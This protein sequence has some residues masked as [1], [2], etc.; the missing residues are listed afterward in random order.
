VPKAPKNTPSNTPTVEQ[1]R[2]FDIPIFVGIDHP[3]FPNVPGTPN[4]TN[5]RK[6]DGLPKDRLPPISNLNSMLL[7]I[8][9]NKPTGARSE[10]SRNSSFSSGSFDSGLQEGQPDDGSSYKVRK[11]SFSSADSKTHAQMEASAFVSKKLDAEIKGAKMGLLYPSPPSKYNHQLRGAPAHPG[12]SRL[13]GQA[14]GPLGPLTPPRTPHNGP[15]IIESADQ[16][17]KVSIDILCSSVTWARRIPSFT[18]LPFNDQ[19]VLLEE[20]WRELFVLNLAQWNI[21]LDIDLMLQ[22]GGITREDS[23][24]GDILNTITDL[25]R[26]QSVVDRFRRMNLDGTE[27]SCLKAIILFKTDIHSLQNRAAIQHLQDEA[28]VMLH[29]FTHRGAPVSRF[30]RLLLRLPILREIAG[31]TI[32]RHFFKGSLYNVHAARGGGV[33]AL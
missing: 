24:S 14:V 6:D 5:H 10:E 21:P 20:G 30:G 31:S 33:F 29:E 23:L 2:R 15:V 17:Y 8:P 13:Q 18:A 12:I 26:L 27:Y 25:V 28:Q 7:K 1:Q 4:K 16:L 22:A 19:T 3:T 9:D 32:E 11:S